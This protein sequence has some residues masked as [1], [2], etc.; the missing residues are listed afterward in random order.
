MIGIYLY[1]P[2]LIPLKVELGTV[3]L[4]WWAGQSAAYL[5]TDCIDYGTSEYNLAK[6]LLLK[7]Y[8]SNTYLLKFTGTHS[9][10]KKF[11]LQ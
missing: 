2:T 3:N 6:F 5:W 9:F 10:F 11:S 7:L 1:T 8:V 4:M